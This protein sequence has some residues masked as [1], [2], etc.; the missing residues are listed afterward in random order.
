MLR[1]CA[2]PNVK[3][4]SLTGKT[5]SHVALSNISLSGA[6]LTRLEDEYLALPDLYVHAA[7]AS[8]VIGIIGRPIG[9]C[10]KYLKN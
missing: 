1:T 5:C 7:K 4:A 6:S 8:D 2:S 9:F 3:A 10:C